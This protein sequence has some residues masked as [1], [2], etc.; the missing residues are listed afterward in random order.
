MVLTHLPPIHTQPN[1]PSQR[2]FIRQDEPTSTIPEYS[3]YR[4][5]LTITYNTFHLSW[6]CSSFFFGPH[7]GH[8]VIDTV[9][10][11]RCQDQPQTMGPRSVTIVTTTQWVTKVSIRDNPESEQRSIQGPEKSCWQIKV[12]LKL[13]YSANKQVYLC[14]THIILVSMLICDTTFKQHTTQA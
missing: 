4:T 11:Y 5:S 12:N 3:G 2:R 10:Q 1:S 9:T 14:L 7:Y 13:H 8:L 6:C